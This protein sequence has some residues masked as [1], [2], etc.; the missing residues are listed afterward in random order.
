MKTTTLLTWVSLFFCSVSW[1]DLK[2]EDARIFAPMKGSNIT[3]GYV[4]V[5]NEGK[6]DAILILKRVAKFKAFETHETLE[7]SGKMIMRK[8][9]SFKIPAGATLEL[10]PGGRHLMLFDPTE[11]IKEGTSLEVL[12]SIDGKDKAVAFNVISR[13]QA[14]DSHSH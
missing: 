5:K 2:F 1:A 11:V 7:E 8:V 3:A 6:K 12:F 4:N 9:G 13:V 14:S 10:K